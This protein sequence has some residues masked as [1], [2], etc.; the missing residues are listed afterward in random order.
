MALTLVGSSVVTVLAPVSLSKIRR[1][2]ILIATRNYTYLLRSL[3]LLPPHCACPDGFF[4][5]RVSA[6]WSVC[7][8]KKVT[9]ARASIGPPSA[10]SDDVV[11]QRRSLLIPAGMA[12][13]GGV[14]YC[15][16]GG[17]Q[18]VLVVTARVAL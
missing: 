18:Y 9:C 6:Q 11:A 7:K 13:L 17:L 15:L 4:H 12:L 8:A 5:G 2:R 14:S 3:R 10:V 1:E 16:C